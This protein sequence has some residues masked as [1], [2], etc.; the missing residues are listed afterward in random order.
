[1]YK[2][3]G[4]TMSIRKVEHGFDKPTALPVNPLSY[5]LSSCGEVNRISTLDPVTNAVPKL[6]T[7]NLP[8]VP[9]VSGAGLQG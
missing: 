2:L 6:P 4:G 8:K 7:T 9:Y 1:M 5:S 3:Q